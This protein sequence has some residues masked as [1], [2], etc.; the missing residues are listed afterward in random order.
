M[1][2]SKISELVNKHLFR[3]WQVRISSIAIG[4]Y[5]STLLFVREK[6]CLVS[7][8]INFSLLSLQS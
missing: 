7:L 6:K 3:S 1:Q 4:N 8:G 2:E 5:I